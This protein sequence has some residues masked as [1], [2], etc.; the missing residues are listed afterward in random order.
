ME[1]AAE[2]P[3]KETTEVAE[4]QP[5]PEEGETKRR[6]PYW[7]FRRS[8]EPKDNEVR[9][10]KQT[11]ASFASFQLRTKLKDF[12][13]VMI[14][15][16]GEENLRTL[17]R[18]INFMTSDPG[19]VLLV[20]T[21]VRYLERGGN[22]ALRNHFKKGPNFDQVFAELE[23]KFEARMAARA[24]KKKELEAAAAAETKKEPDSGAA[25]AEK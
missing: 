5:A 19:F 21:E 15:A 10:G 6:A 11:R 22:V 16:I 1:K 9:I 3:K 20:K 12:D 2:K 17:S 25:A 24:E 23:T 7:S 4:T 13:M 8:E 18:V 14:S